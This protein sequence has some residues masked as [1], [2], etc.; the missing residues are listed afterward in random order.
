[1]GGLRESAACSRDR[2]ERLAETRQLLVESCASLTSE[3]VDGLVEAWSR[4]VDRLFYFHRIA[5]RSYFTFL[6]LS[7]QVGSYLP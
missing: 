7:D 5:C 2:A 4:T 6:S 3:S 1:V